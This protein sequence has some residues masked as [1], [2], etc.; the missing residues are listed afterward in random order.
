[1]S[2]LKEIC[3]ANADEH[4]PVV[5]SVSAKGNHIVTNKEKQQ[6]CHRR[7]PSALQAVFLA[8]NQGRVV[9]NPPSNNLAS[10][11]FFQATQTWS[12]SRSESSQSNRHETTFSRPSN[13]KSKQRSHSDKMGSSISK[14]QVSN[15]SSTDT[16]KMKCSRFQFESFHEKML[17]PSSD[18]YSNEVSCSRVYPI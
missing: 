11:I 10:K 16:Y 15:R 2:L 5:P 6:K 14:S 9:T 1:M 18:C 8:S 17:N 7:I 4:S 13:S 12:R 3:Q